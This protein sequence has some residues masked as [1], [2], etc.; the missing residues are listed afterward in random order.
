MRRVI[1]AGC[2]NVEAFHLV[3]PVRGCPASLGPG[4]RTGA[5]RKGDLGTSVSL[6]KGTRCGWSG[7]C[8]ATRGTGWLPLSVRNDL[9]RPGIG[10]L[11]RN[12]GSRPPLAP[13]SKTT[14]T[15]RSDISSGRGHRCWAARDAVSHRPKNYAHCC[16]KVIRNDLRQAPPIMCTG[17]DLSR[18]MV[19]TSVALRRS[20]GLSVWFRFSNLDWR[21]TSSGCDLVA[22]HRPIFHSFAIGEA[23]RSPISRAAGLRNSD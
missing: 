5:P 10:P 22:G 4:S 13:V 6:R 14:R 7:C 11:R 8:C 3:Q 20:S 1:T 18:G 15:S 17:R 2:H 9:G 23:K 21:R 19:A 16:S 12:A